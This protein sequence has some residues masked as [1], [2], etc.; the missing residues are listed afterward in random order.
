M[1]CSSGAKFRDIQ[2]DGNQRKLL[3]TPRHDFSA[4]TRS[5]KGELLSSDSSVAYS[6][7]RPLCATLAL[8]SG[9]RPLWFKARPVQITHRFPSHSFN[10]NLRDGA[11]SLGVATRASD[12]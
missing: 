1:R 2:I 8:V 3:F 12:S 4:W 11:F 6:E 9:K 10:V 7:I 5:V